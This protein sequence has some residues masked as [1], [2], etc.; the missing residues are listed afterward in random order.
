MQNNNLYLER[1]ESLRNVMREQNIACTVIC[2]SPNL[3]YMTSYSPKKCERLQVAVVPADSEPLMIVP[4]IYTVD[5][6]RG[7]AVKD[8][9]V[10]SDGNDVV[11]LVRD[12]LTEK[13]LLGKTIA[14]DDTI[15]FRQYAYFMNAS[16]DSLFVPAGSL[17]SKLRMH[18]SPEEVEKMKESGRLTDEAID[19]LVKNIMNG[20]SE[21]ELHTWIEFELSNKGMRQGFSNLIASGPNTG[22]PH[23]VSGTRI[24]QIGDAVYLDIGGA[25]DH[26]WSDSTR[27]FHI[28][29][30]SEKY[31]DTYK[32]VREAQQLAA[33]TIRPGV[34]ACDV[35]RV[36]HEYLEKF[37][38]GKYYS[39]RVGHG[40]GLDGHEI[41]NLSSDNT[42]ILEPGMTFSCEPG[43]YF[44][45]EWGI[46]IEDTVL[47]TDTGYMSFNHFTKDLIVI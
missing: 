24:P 28:G 29:T 10:W 44:V 40:V 34:R 8:L 9:R 11:R 46:R 27:S 26:Y 47:V 5:A 18:K 19:M 36:S 35:N 12:I 23:H 16:P 1:F 38:L 17:F 14:V 13:K 3:Y 21:A 42:A 7:C 22:S 2:N 45:G 25:F 39:H 33:D 43:V 32:R 20:K 31:I 41:P 6:E 30:P 15:E 37:G 4:Q